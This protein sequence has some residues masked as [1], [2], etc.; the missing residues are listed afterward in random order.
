MS[1]TRSLRIY[2]AGPMTGKPNY[3]K[4]AFDD[5]ALGYSEQSHLPF[6]PFVASSRVWLKTFGFTFNDS[7]DRCDYGDPMLR[8]F[9]AEDIALLLSC[10]RVVLL[11]GWRESKGARIEAQVAQ[12]FGIEIV[13]HETGAPVGL[14][15][16]VRPYEVCE[17]EPTQ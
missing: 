14:L 7:L 13:E 12:L 16:D 6:T 2:I 1:E 9:F 15:V 4:A 10:D 17:P 11:P 5:A 8:E 3:N